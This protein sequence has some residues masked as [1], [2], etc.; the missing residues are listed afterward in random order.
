MD[1]RI[2]WFLPK[3]HVY[4]N[5]MVRMSTMHSLRVIQ[6]FLL[7]SFQPNKSFFP[8]L[9]TPFHYRSCQRCEC[10]KHQSNKGITP[11]QPHRVDHVL[12]HTRC[13]RTQQTPT[14]IQS[15]RHSCGRLRIQ[16]YQQ[17]LL[18]NHRARYGSAANK[19]DDKGCCE[20]GSCS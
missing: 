7:R 14:H 2:R 5:D 18:H 4:D 13:T 15:R 9:R 6:I 12:N 1:W 3:I 11:A 8:P 17:R 16:I 10:N 20:I 19:Q